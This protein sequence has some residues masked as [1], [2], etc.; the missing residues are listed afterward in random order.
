ML[1]QVGTPGG[2]Q[3]LLAVGNDFLGSL[4]AIAIILTVIGLVVALIAFL[5]GQSS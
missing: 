5:S 1:K 3:T 4:R 2:R